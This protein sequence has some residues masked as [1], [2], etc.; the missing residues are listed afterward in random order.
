[1]DFSNLD[2][3]IIT[4]Y[5][6][7]GYYMYLPAIFIYNDITEYKWLDD[8]DKKYRIVGDEWKFQISKQENGN[9]VTKY[10]GGVS[11]LQAPFFFAAH[12]YALMTHHP[13]DGLFQL[14]RPHGQPGLEA[15]AGSRGSQ[16]VR[17]C[18]WPHHDAIPV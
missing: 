15:L 8:V 7:M 1:M 17:S 3:H 13:A 2:R 18:P 10:L 12:G 5:D 14:R 11:I 9:Y 6:G 4:N 16:S